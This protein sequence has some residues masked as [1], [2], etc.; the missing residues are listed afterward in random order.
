MGS[1]SS[2]PPQSA[3][4]TR[5]YF[6]SD[7]PKLVL[8]SKLGKKGMIGD[9]KFMKS[10]CMRADGHNIV[11]K[12]Y[13]R[14]S[15]EDLS[16]MQEKLQFLWHTLSPV[17]FP[18][19]LPYMM[20]IRGQNVKQK[21]QPQPIYLLRQHLA[22]NLY[23]RCLSRPFLTLTEKLWLLFQ[24]FVAIEKCHELGVVHGDIKPENVLSTNWNFVVLTDFA[25]YKP[26]VIPNDDPTDFQYYFDTAGNRACY[27]A[28][29]RFAPQDSISNDSDFNVNSMTSTVKNGLNLKDVSVGGRNPKRNRNER[30]TTAMD[31]FSLGCTIAEIVLDCKCPL[32]DLPGMVQYVSR[33]SSGQPVFERLDDDGSPCKALLSRIEDPLIRN[34]IV[35]MTQLLPHKRLSVKE[36][37]CILEGTMPFPGFVGSSADN[38]RKVTGSTAEAPAI[39]SG[40]SASSSSHY[41]FPKYFGQTL[42]PFYMNLHWTGVTPDRR[43]SMLCRG[44]SSL[45]ESMTG[46]GDE[47]GVLVLTKLLEGIPDAMRL[48]PSAPGTPGAGNSSFAADNISD[49]HV[50]VSTTA[51]AKVRAEYMK[52]ALY[53]PARSFSSCNSSTATDAKSGS[54][55]LCGY[56]QQLQGSPLD[57]DTKGRGGSPH[58]Q[59]SKHTDKHSA[60]SRTTEELARRCQEF[61]NHVKQESLTPSIQNTTSD[62]QAE[63]Q[64]LTSA[65][66]ELSHEYT[67]DGRFLH[68]LKPT[69]GY[70]RFSPASEHRDLCPGT[71]MLVTLLGTIFRHLRFPQSKI[72]LILLL[73]RLGPL[74]DCEVL[75]QRAVPMLTLCLEDEHAQVR[76]V[77][78]RALTKLLGYVRTL[79]ANEA[80]IFPL[81]L[82]P[83]F[84]RLVKDP[85]VIVRVAFAECLGSLAETSKRFLELAHLASQR[86]VITSKQASGISTKS[87]RLSAASIGAKETLPTALSLAVGNAVSMAAE[88]G[89]DLPPA[90]P[91]T[92]TAGD[93][94]PVPGAVVASS[95]A[96]TSSALAA[97]NGYV[98]FPYT[99][100][101][102]E[103]HSH[104][105]Q[106]IKALSDE[107][108]QGEQRRGSGLAS[109]S[110]QLKRV[111]LHDILRVCV[112]YGPEETVS[113]LLPHLLTFFSDQDWELRSSFWQNVASVCAVIGPTLTEAY[114]LPGLDNALVDVEE[115]VVVAAL[116]LLRTLCDLRLLSPRNT[117]TY[118]A[119]K[120]PALLLGPSVPTREA[121]AH[122]IAAASRNMGA[123]DTAVLIMPLLRKLLKKDI[124]IC[125]ELTAEQLLTMLAAPV[126]RVAYRTALFQ[127][128]R[129]Y[130][131]NNLAASAD[132]IVSYSSSISG[133]DEEPD[134]LTKV[135]LSMMSDYIDQAAKELASK[136]V[137]WRHGLS[138]GINTGS[139]S[140]SLRRSLSLRPTSSPGSL[141]TLLTVTTTYSLSQSLQTLMVPH[142]KYGARYYRK[143]T[144][145]QRSWANRLLELRDP[146]A[147][148][149]LYGISTSHYDAVR[150][151]NL[152]IDST[153]L[154]KLADS[155][156][157]AHRPS[158][159]GQVGHP[160]AHANTAV[161]STALSAATATAAYAQSLAPP[162][163][164]TGVHE[165]QQ[166]DLTY[167]ALSCSKYIRTLGI[168]PLPPDVG[169]LVQPTLGEDR[170]L[171]YYNG[172]TE[173]LD[174]SSSPD[175]LVS[176]GKQAWRPKENCLVCNM[177]EH[178]QAVNR[179]AVSPDHSFFA[180][181]SSDGTVKIWQLH[182]LDKVPLP[183]SALTYRGHRSPVTDVTPIENSHSMASAS[184]DG[185]VHVWRVDVEPRTADDTRQATYG[186]LR[187]AGLGIVKQLD[188]DEGAVVGMQHFN[189]EV[190]SVLM[191]ATRSGGL[192]GWD[193]RSSREALYFRLGPELGLTTALAVA[194]DRSWAVVGTSRGF[195][196]LW[197]LRYNLLCRLWQHSS[198]GPIWKLACSKSLLRT[199]GSGT[200][201][202]Q[203]VG[204]FPN[205]GSPALADTEGA[206]LFVA[207]G[208][209][210][211]AVW[212]LPEAGECL[213]CFRNVTL[214]SDPSK[215]LAP[216]PV[217]TEVALPRHPGG[218]I[219]GAYAASPAAK[220]FA[221][222]VERGI[223]PSA[224]ESSSVRAL[225]GRTPLHL[226]TGGTD[227][228]IRYWD[229]KSPVKCYVVSGLEPGQPK[230]TFEAPA[231]DGINGR[232]FVCYDSLMPS[233]DATLSSHLPLRHDRGPLSPNPSFRST[234]L[235]LKTIDLPVRGLLSSSTDGVIKLWK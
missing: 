6:N 234:I 180:S 59:H 72:C 133:L 80:D 130:L 32:L 209:G 164:I 123:V 33:E 69:A 182:G 163:T 235:D 114:I 217:L 156:H 141:D 83:V 132:L 129:K 162:L 41:P 214:S 68:F 93:H 202:A 106:C 149:A 208:D 193:F 228:T 3:Q 97:K 204:G 42:L 5:A 104:V 110:S 199:G 40:A 67:G 143:L 119:S 8:Q 43:L 27:L 108:S 56:I 167:R 157:G 19:L 189:G 77:A 220:A 75:L 102:K 173:E 161:S 18:N 152:G 70:T 125:A 39:Q 211:T 201:N 98:E 142:Q 47:E 169:T 81:C 165:L 148:C 92:S 158:H 216:L 221:L 36:Y 78:L 90:P 146:A 187:I 63:A 166:S 231:G 14:L 154:A 45:L 7:L 48:Q 177:L 96:N 200:N 1:A 175:A 155:S 171:Q 185:S 82:L 232:L 101:L 66:T 197:D 203:G 60:S 91:G 38:E 53:R 124:Q 99:A 21:N 145:D 186:P 210:E 205:A 178:T 159:S 113:Q 37:R 55:L 181:A 137:Q 135:K 224:I 229:F 4:A 11:V 20:W 151:L 111:L 107:S 219:Q 195:V 52:A 54:D 198:A 184:K 86:A 84:K 50:E 139:F 207:A 223:D 168:P 160:N 215:A 179:L 126:S 64:A 206:Y 30:L 29:E 120:G 16:A 12:V 121:T 134:A 58:T 183:Q 138:G 9:G 105:S 212:G 74:C 122:F 103:L 196:A 88:S 226:V 172:Y 117:L 61:L 233:V 51:Q 94:M 222:D 170:K 89:R 79:P 144:E 15:D 213:K 225:V 227:R 230:P 218:V 100:K 95:A 25:P 57:H 73:T 85:E 194:P 17:K 136:T 87:V 131:E 13:M 2:R 34:V 22:H 31:V 35:H 147:I 190:A 127:R 115:R 153:V 109:T 191:Y 28:P 71:E 128:Q 140:A 10:Y 44:Y 76:T 116:T 26:T 176:Q 188:T 112:F 118:I 174:V 62:L 23:D 24:L 46:T 192:H 150:A 65:A 49:I